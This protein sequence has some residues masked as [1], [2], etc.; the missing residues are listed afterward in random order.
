MASRKVLIAVLLM[1]AVLAM[2]AF[3]LQTGADDAS[4]CV[5]CHTNPDVMKKLVVVPKLGG[6]EAVG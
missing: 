2:G 6:G 4:G 3:A 1:A 5:D